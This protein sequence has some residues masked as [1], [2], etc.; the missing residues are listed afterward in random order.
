MNYYLA[1]DGSALHKDTNE[2]GELFLLRAPKREPVL[3]LSHA[4]VH[5]ALH[6]PGHIEPNEYG[7]DILEKAD[8]AD[9]LIT[10]NGVDLLKGL[11]DIGM[12]SEGL[13]DGGDIFRVG[14]ASE[15][16]D[17]PSVNECVLLPF[18]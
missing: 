2:T 11:V 6:V 16:V 5:T 8:E 17:K 12:L 7:T 1:L 9:A 15:L 13:E 14:E 3:D 18:A 10:P 4:L